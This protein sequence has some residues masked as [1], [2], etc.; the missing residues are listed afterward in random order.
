MCLFGMFVLVFESLVV[1]GGCVCLGCLFLCLCLWWC[2]V[3]VFVCS[4]CSCDCVYG[5]TCLVPSLSLWGFVLGRTDF[6][7]RLK[8]HG[9]GVVEK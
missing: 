3:G 6:M 4:D 5:V 2:L 7:V 8:M 1:L 9:Q